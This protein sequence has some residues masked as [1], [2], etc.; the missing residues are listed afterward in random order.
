MS[1]RAV[2]RPLGRGLAARSESGKTL[3]HVVQGGAFRIGHYAAFLIA[4]ERLELLD[5]GACRR[6]EIAV[7]DAL[8]MAER[9]KIGLGFSTPIDAPRGII[10]T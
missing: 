3:R 10:A 4:G 2:R 6:T 1:E 5:C 8:Q 9:D 7:R